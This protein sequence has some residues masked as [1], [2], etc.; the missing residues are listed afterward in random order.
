MSVIHLKALAS[1]VSEISR[2]N[3]KKRV[4]RV[5]V[6]LVVR[7]ETIASR[8]LYYNVEQKCLISQTFFT[9]DKEFIFPLMG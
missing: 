6:V 1:T 2:K 4:V 5:A 7:S 8:S 9:N 3:E